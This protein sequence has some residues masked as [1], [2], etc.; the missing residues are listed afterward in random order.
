MTPLDQ[1]YDS[2]STYSNYH[3]PLTDGYKAREQQDKRQTLMR[4]NYDNQRVESGVS[5]GATDGGAVEWSDLT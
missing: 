1:S 5:G 2:N 3:N 4:T